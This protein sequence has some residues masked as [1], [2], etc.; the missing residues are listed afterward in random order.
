MFKKFVSVK[1]LVVLTLLGLFLVG[2][3]PLD[4]THTV[5]CS[6]VTK[7]CH[8]TVTNLENRDVKYSLSLGFELAGVP[9]EP[10]FSQNVPE[11][12]IGWQRKIFFSNKIEGVLKPGQK[13]EQDISLP[14]GIF[15]YPGQALVDAYLWTESPNPF[16][17]AYGNHHLYTTV[18]IPGPDLIAPWTTPPIEYQLTCSSNVGDVKLVVSY[19]G[20]WGDR[21]VALYLNNEMTIPWQVIAIKKG[22]T[23]EVF[24]LPI[25][26][27]TFLIEVDVEGHREMTYD[28]QRD[29]HGYRQYC[30][31]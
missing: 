7:I 12:Q 5:T 24:T 26:D 3:S 28:N 13:I 15:N 6:I 16:S 2:C 10:K 21:N 30:I 18:H 4:V 27:G 23:R 22:E 11:R 25:P 9:V 31:P 1:W 20:T 14:D 8:V 29:Y 17:A 19:D